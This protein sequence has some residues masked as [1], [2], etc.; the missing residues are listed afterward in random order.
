MSN[1][2]EIMDMGI[3]CL[4]DQLGV[5]KAEQF[6]AAIKREDFDYTVWQREFFDGVP[7]GDFLQKAAEYGKEHPHK[8]KGKRI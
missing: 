1:T 4:I 8:G 5:V 3:A 7:P 2:A 6:I